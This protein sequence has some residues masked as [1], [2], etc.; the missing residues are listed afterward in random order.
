MNGRGTAYGFTL[1]EVLV[2]MAIFALLLSVL[3]GSLD[4]VTRAMGAAEKAVDDGARMR[5]GSEFLTRLVETAYPLALADGR[6][7]V[8]QFAGD[9]KSLRFAVD[10]PGFVGV[11]GVHEVAL[12]VRDEEGES[13]LWFAWR[14]MMMDADGEA[15]AGEFEERVLV[16]DITALAVRYFGADKDE[17]PRWSD[18]WSK[19][20]G[21]PVLVEMTL[22]DANDTPWPLLIMRPR[23]NTPRYLSV[24]KG[25]AGADEPASEE[26]NLQQL[27]GVPD[28][29]QLEGSSGA[30]Q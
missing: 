22:Q 3:Y 11:S 27:P 13:A 1:V 7:W 25:G 5:I 23:A 6:G 18:E 24:R 29:A 9:A 16:P 20:P 12:S 8:M 30:S 19:M 28:P 4:S 2:A 26:E 17:D 21:M 15:V 14:P 10:M